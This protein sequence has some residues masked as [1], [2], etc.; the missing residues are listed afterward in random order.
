[1]I[2][3]EFR[4]TEKQ[5]F[6]VAL[7]DLSRSEA[8]TRH[9]PAD[10]TGRWHDDRTT[11][12]QHTQWN[13]QESK[14]DHGPLSDC[15]SGLTLCAWARID[16]RDELAPHLG[17]HA[18][19]ALVPDS[20]FIL[21]AYRKWGEDCVNRLL[22]DFAFAIWDSRRQT[23]F[24]ARDPMGVRPFY[25]HLSGDLFLFAGTLQVFIA[26]EGFK[27]E[28]LRRWMAEYL[29]R[30]SMSFESTP[31]RGI[32]KLPPGHCLRIGREGN[33]LR[34]YHRL[35]G[36][37][38]LRLKRPEDYVA[39]Y[40]EELEK[41]IRRRLRSAY[42]LGTESSGGVDSSTI[43]AF[44]SKM[45]PDPTRRLHAFGFA[46]HEK[47]REYIDAVAV[48]CALAGNHVFQHYDVS[49]EEQAAHMRRALDIL[50]YP[51]EH[52]NSTAHEP[53]YRKAQELGVRTLLSGFGGDEFVTNPGSVAMDEFLHQ[54][55]Y[56]RLYRNLPGNPL[57]RAL[58][59]GKRLLLPRR[60]SL[61]NPRF[62]K[63]F[64]QRWQTVPLKERQAQAFGLFDRYMQGAQYD[65]GWRTL[66]DF[67]LN[68]RWAP[69]VPTRLENCTLM[70]AARKVEY[71]WPLLD[72]RLVQLFLSIPA[73]QKYAKGVGRLLHR[74]AITGIVPHKVAWKPSKN[75]GDA[76]APYEGPLHS[77]MNPDAL[78]ADLADLVDREKLHPPQGDTA[79]DL[80]ALRFH[81][82]A[83]NKVAWLN[84][85]LTELDDGGD[86]EA[87]IGSGLLLAGIE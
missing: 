27:A 59:L 71:R 1:M 57:M 43:T 14:S 18:E 13:T 42:P 51:V 31:Y 34:Q 7:E 37:T 61:R 86:V 63:F 24:C 44:A 65:H 29:V 41:A 47:E 82:L 28:P 46:T 49:P 52:E 30:V 19:D 87:G 67:V 8:L 10:T 58:R 38:T 84:L 26:L 6:G 23:L 48:D 12:I 62:E 4:R 2:F 32:L 78:H 64:L 66:N 15:E 76:L 85:W 25:Y 68:N 5:G 53:F 36:E 77:L 73:D 16:N 21:A 75:M 40:R 11:L 56:I 17:L 55:R 20:Q 54:R 74:K 72:A 45:L 79:G 39:A 9:I 80:M 81:S 22:G 69:F 3:G 35:N 83:W 60:E 70:A 50:G 33:T